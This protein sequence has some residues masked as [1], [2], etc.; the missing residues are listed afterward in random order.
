MG[1]M[2]TGWKWKTGTQ[3]R[4]LFGWSISGWIKEHI[5]EYVAV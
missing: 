3:E 2:F 4:E 1:V 5:M